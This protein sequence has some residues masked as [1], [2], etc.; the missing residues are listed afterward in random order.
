MVHA[1]E[2]LGYEYPDVRFRTTVSPGTYV[3]ALARDLGTRL[4]TSAHLRALRRET[5][6]S[7]RVE[8]ALPLEDITPAAVIPPLAVLGH[9]GTLALTEDAARAVAHGRPVPVP[10]AG[11]RGGEADAIAAVAPGERL[12]AVGRVDEGRFRPEVVLEALG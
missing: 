6:G 8:D 11:P 7:L 5:I 3:R 12:V 10:H 2:L 9:L 1:M 4:G